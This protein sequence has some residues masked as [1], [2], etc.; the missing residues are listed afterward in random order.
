MFWKLLNPC[1]RLR[2]TIINRF[3]KKNRH[4]KIQNF[5]WMGAASV[6]S[7]SVMFIM[8]E[9]KT[10]QVRWNFSCVNIS[11]VSSFCPQPWFHGIIKVLMSSLPHVLM[12]FFPHVLLSSCPPVLMSSCPHVL[13]SS[14]PHVLMSS[15]PHALMSSWPHVLMCSYPHVSSCVLMCEYFP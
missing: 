12:S 8:G 6:H 13:L 9:T 2:S 1:T 7:A 5:A 3:F 15:C 4:F 14:F 10:T 11:L